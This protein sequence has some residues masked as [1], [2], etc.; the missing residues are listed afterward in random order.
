M[1]WLTVQVIRESTSSTVLFVFCVKCESCAWVWGNG[2]VTIKAE[3]P[4]CSFAPKTH[5]LPCCVPSLCKGV[6][7]LSRGQVPTHSSL[8]SNPE[9]NPPSDRSE[10]EILRGYHIT[11][12]A[13]NLPNTG[14]ISKA[15]CVP[16]LSKRSKSVSYV[17]TKYG[18]VFRWNILLWY[19]TDN[20]V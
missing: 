2:R 10:S 5:V 1:T 16:L 12:R 14:C 7:I 3:K 15:S 18:F 13:D 19:N 11:Y 20:D 8:S 6:M 4:T 17:G 9:E